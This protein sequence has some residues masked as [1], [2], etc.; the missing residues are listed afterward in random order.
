MHNLTFSANLIPSYL[1]AGTYS[2]DIKLFTRNNKT[3][4]NANLLFDVTN[5]LPNW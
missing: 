5:V 3:I 4:I 2:Y 1:P